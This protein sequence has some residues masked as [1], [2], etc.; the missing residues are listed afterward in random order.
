MKKVLFLLKGY[1]R[2]S[3]T[4]IAQEILNLEYRKLDITIASMRKPHDGFSHP[5]H[6][7]IKAPYFYLPEYLHQH[8]FRVLKA[9]LNL[10]RS[11]NY[12][13]LIS[14]FKKDF[15]KERTRNRIR[16]LGQAFVLAYE[17]P[18]DI[19]H[20][21]AHFL[22]TP[23]SVAHYTSILTGKPWS[24]SAHAKDIWTSPQWDIQQ[25]LESMDWLTTCTKFGQKYLSQYGPEK[26]FLNYHGIDLNNFSNYENKYKE[27]DQVPVILLSVSR[28]VTKKGLPFLLQAL[29]KLKSTDWHFIHIGGGEQLDQLKGMAKELGIDQQI[30]WLGP[31]PQ[32]TVLSFYRK[33]DIFLF[34]SIIADNGDRDGVPNVLIEAMSQKLACVATD[35]DGTKEAIK[36]NHNGYLCPP[37]NPEI[38]AKK[39]DEL[40]Q[41]PNLRKQLGAQAQQDAIKYFNAENLIDDLLN[42]FI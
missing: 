5:V 22:H 40:I 36:D 26:V 39:I 11:N 6:K 16:R 38:L 37:K 9:W 2:L 13:K 14:V 25:K 24:C 10:R 17:M 8:P 23:A 18:Q 42:K 41:K 33:A 28:A 21:H 27:S 34:P 1:P 31:R 3:E 30:S 29:H 19:E 12:S 7:K 32:P 4:F 35:L 15:K 20:I